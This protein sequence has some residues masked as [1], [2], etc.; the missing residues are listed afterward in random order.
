[1]FCQKLARILPITLAFPVTMN[2][3]IAPPYIPIYSTPS[4]NTFCIPRSANRENFS[5]YDFCNYMCT[6]IN[7]H[8]QTKKMVEQMS[9]LVKYEGMMET[10]LA[11]NLL[12]T[13][14]KVIE[15]LEAEFKIQ[16]QTIRFLNGEIPTDPNRKDKQL[17]EFFYN[18]MKTPSAR[19]PLVYS[20]ILEDHILEKYA[21]EFEEL[22]RFHIPD[23]LR[24]QS[25]FAICRCE[26]AL[27]NDDIV[28]VLDTVKLINT[29]IM[30][31]F[32]TFIK[33]T[34]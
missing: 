2:P 13:S 14:K 24:A 19:L 15:Y 33:E 22:K 32:N 23:L 8:Y 30:N 31:L 20:R 10:P 1:M 25:N 7:P 12:E 9:Y 21:A 29:I 18:N 11:K 4:F 34:S 6:C 5:K 28:T 27:E 16:E 17:S 26:Y 3:R